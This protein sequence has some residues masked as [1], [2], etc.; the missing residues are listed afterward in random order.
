MDARVAFCQSMLKENEATE[1]IFFKRLIFSDESWMEAG[2]MSRGAWQSPTDIVYKSR[3]HHPTKVMIWGA[4]AGDGHVFYHWCDFTKFYKDEA[5]RE[6]LPGEKR[7]EFPQELKLGSLYYRKS[8]LESH[9]LPYA[10]THE[11]IILME[12]GAPAHRAILTKKWCK[13]R[14][15][16]NLSRYMSTTRELMLRWPADSPDLNPIENLWNQTKQFKNRKCPISAGEIKRVCESYLDSVEAKESIKKL[17][18]SFK[19]RLELCI[20]YKGKKI[21]Y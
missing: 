19:K 2:D 13:D 5:S 1:G 18:V 16:M 20:L 12:D 14:K 7:E 11:N 17:H 8:I 10:A 21:P 4:I 9:F 3:T 15:A 6:L